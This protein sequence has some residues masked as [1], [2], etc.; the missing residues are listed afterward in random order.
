MCPLYK[1][2]LKIQ[3]FNI[4]EYTRLESY[5][6]KLLTSFQLRDRISESKFYRYL[7]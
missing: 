5:Q 4:L 1:Y 6:E 3:L 2:F 7:K